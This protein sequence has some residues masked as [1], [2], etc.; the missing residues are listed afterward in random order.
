MVRI[1]FLTDRDRIDG[2]YLL[3]TH[4]VVRRLRGQV[5]EVAE[6]DLELLNEHRIA[7]SVVPIPEPT[8]SHEAVRNPLTVDL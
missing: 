3:A 5:F 1:Q 4:S 6:R 2:N 8:D 7:Y